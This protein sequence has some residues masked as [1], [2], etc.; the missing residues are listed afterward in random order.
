MKQCSLCAH[1]CCTVHA[2]RIYIN[3]LNSPPR[4]DSMTQRRFV[5]VLATWLII[6]ELLVSYWFLSRAAFRI[7]LLSLL[8][9]AVY[10]CELVCSII[11][12]N[13]SMC[14]ISLFK[15]DI[16]YALSDWILLLNR[17]VARHYRNGYY[18]LKWQSSKILVAFLTHLDRPRPEY[19]LLAVLI[20]I[21]RGPLILDFSSRLRI[22]HLGTITSFG[23]FVQIADKLFRS[24]F[25]NYRITSEIYF[26]AIKKI[27]GSL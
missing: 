27:L 13:W 4:L 1:T 26:W 20:Y 9:V 2:W 16:I 6:G 10:I 23:K 7:H 3:C 17:I 11:S 8:L 19:E 14:K 5:A 12:F 21:F 18:C 25:W 24:I 22:F 15:Q